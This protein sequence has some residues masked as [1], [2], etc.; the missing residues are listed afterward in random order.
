MNMNK[1]SC[2]RREFLTA[3]GLGV[4]A[5]AMPSC[6]SSPGKFS[7]DQT[8]T[9]AQIC[10]TQLGFGGYEHDVKSFKQAV[11]QI[12]ALK[13]AFVVIC[14]DLVNAPDEKSFA[15][16]NEIKAGFNVPCYC[17]S[18]NHDVG[19]KPTPVSLQHYR[20][21]VGE[22]Y[23]SFEHKGHTFVI[24]NTQ[25][26]KAP[27][28]DESEKQDSWLAAAL[29]TA[30][31]KSSRTFVVGHYPLFLEK[32]DEDEQ[33]FNLPVAKRK[34]LLD[35]FEERGV[36]AVLGGHTHRLLINEHNGIQLVNAETTSQNFDKR[37]YGFRLWHVGDTR[38]FK[39]D[40]VPL[41]GS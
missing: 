36:V 22:D 25:L 3:A 28:K 19:N 32:P 6:V 8:F 30:A 26:W 23:C 2:T 7:E 38:P 15:D 11:Q 27:V 24:V 21:V 37:P 31:N 39:H 29:E 9:F 40:F 41:E 4:A 16:F 20:K 13:P 18:G 12:N 17:A 34:K 35:L 14:G 1:N 33:Y 10:D 5:I